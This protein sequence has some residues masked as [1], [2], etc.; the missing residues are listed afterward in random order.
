MRSPAEPFQTNL[1]AAASELV[2][3][4]NAVQ[5]LRGLLSA[6][7][8]VTL[9][10]PGG[11]AKTKLALEVARGLFPVGSKPDPGAAGASIDDVVRV[12]HLCPA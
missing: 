2:G 7:R 11:I 10:G 1:P 9:T 4:T 6:Y 8:V 3:R 5:H 12:G